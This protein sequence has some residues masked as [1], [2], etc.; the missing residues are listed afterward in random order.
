M[1]KKFSDLRKKLDKTDNPSYYDLSCIDVLDRNGI[2]A[3][4][5]ESKDSASNEYS[6]MDYGCRMIYD[7]KEDLY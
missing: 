2:A 6:Y 4:G 5:E 7:L 3:D 1:A